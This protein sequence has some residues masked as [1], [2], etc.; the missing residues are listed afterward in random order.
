MPAFRA[1]LVD[2]TVWNWLRS[3]IED[4]SNVTQGLRNMQNEVLSANSRVT[5]RI[6][7][8]EQQ[9]EDLNNQQ[10]KLLDLFLNGDFSKKLIDERK[11]KIDQACRKLLDERNELNSHINQSVADDTQLS[12]IEEYCSEIRSKLVNATF[13][14]KRRL[15]EMFDVHGKL[16]IENN[17]RLIEVTCLLQQQPLSLVL[18]SHS[19]NTGVIEIKPYAYRKTVQFR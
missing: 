6:E 8:I 2:A 13:E 9:L 19:S 16:I 17:Q 15:I 10:T 7:L 1:D 4:P 5:T 3:L 14:S 11:T 12:E 18:T